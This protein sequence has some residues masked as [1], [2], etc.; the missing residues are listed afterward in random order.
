M[1]IIH[2]LIILSLSMLAISCGTKHI[3]PEG[4]P[5]T[6]NPVGSHPLVKGYAEGRE[7]ALTPDTGAA[8][9]LVLFEHTARQLG[10][11]ALKSSFLNQVPIHLTYSP[12]QESGFAQA[13]VLDAPVGEFDG[14]IGWP[15]IQRGVWQLDLAGKRHAFRQSIPSYVAQWKSLKIMSNEP[16]MRVKTSDGKVA[17]IDTGASRAIHLNKKSFEALLAQNPQQP[18]TLYSGYSPAA[19]EGYFAKRC[20]KAENYRLGDVQFENVMIYETFAEVTGHGQLFD[21]DLLVGLEAF[22]NREIW[23][24]GP[25]R[26]LYVSPPRNTAWSP[27]RVSHIRAVFTP[28]DDLKLRATVLRGGVAA[29]AGLRTGDELVSIGG[30]RRITDRRLKEILSKPGKRASVLVRRD[31]RVRR[32]TWTVPA[33]F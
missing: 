7:L 6:I 27:G 13:Y 25:N 4:L 1:R 24:D 21:I 11:T 31:G 9:S 26:K 5:T 2:G 23:I 30:N 10:L 14:L 28:D 32:L 19:R 22:A 3:H 20:L 8:Q 17:V 33:N 16:I 15:E 18:V 12:F 29:K